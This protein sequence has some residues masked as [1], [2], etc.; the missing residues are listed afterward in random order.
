MATMLTAGAPAN[1]S[2]PS[3]RAG[4]RQARPLTSSEIEAFLR[5]ARWAVLS[6]IEADGPYAV[7]VAF[8]YD[9]GACYIASGPGRKVDNI[10]RSPGVCLTVVEVDDG[11]SAAVAWRSVVVRGTAQP[12]T[13]LWEKVRG[14]RALRRQFRG[15]DALTPQ[16]VQRF[17]RAGLLRLTPNE[18][19]GRSIDG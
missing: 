5:G 3:P 19:S 14:F 16:D 6:T 8:G 17:A 12:V 15:T 4:S 9:G 13:A 11:R 7:P 1:P 10:V 18:V 2:A